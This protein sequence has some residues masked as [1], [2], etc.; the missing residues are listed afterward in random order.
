MKVPKYERHGTPIIERILY[1]LEVMLWSLVTLFCV[2][3]LVVG[4]LVNF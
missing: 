1:F 4:I 3:N 2:G